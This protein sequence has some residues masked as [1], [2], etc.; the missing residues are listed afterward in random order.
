MASPNLEDIFNIGA[1]IMGSNINGKNNTVSITTGDAVIK[2]TTG[3]KTQFWQ[4]VGFA[5]RPALA[6]PG[7]G[8]A[9]SINIVRANGDISIATRDLRDQA[10][11]GNLSAGETCIYASGTDGEGQARIALKKD[12]SVTLSTTTDSPDGGI[13]NTDTGVGV[14]LRIDPDRFSF[15]A[16]WGKLIFDASGFHVQT[17]SGASFDLSNVN[18]PA[19]IGGVNSARITASSITFDAPNVCLGPSPTSGGVLG[20]MPAVFGILPPAAPL[21]PILGVGVGAVTVAAASSTKIFIAP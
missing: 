11:Y 14:Y 15:V 7:V 18:L 2:E 4:Q 3:P 5:S 9:Q 10:I 20:Y 12:G 13:R 8:A 1:S 16:P 17:I 21:V 19:P 6:A